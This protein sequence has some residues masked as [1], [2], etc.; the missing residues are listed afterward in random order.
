LNQAAVP[1]G[2]LNYGYDA[3]GRR[4]MEINGAVY[5]PTVQYFLYDDLNQAASWFNASPI[6]DLSTY[7]EELGLDE[8]FMA[9]NGTNESFLRDALGSTVALTNF[10]LTNSHKERAGRVFGRSSWARQNAMIQFQRA[11]WRVFRKP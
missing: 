9:N 10:S 7:L 3:F 8:L 6:S 4:D 5:P 1:G 2:T 11:V